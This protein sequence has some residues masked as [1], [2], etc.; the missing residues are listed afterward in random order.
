MLG[1]ANTSF[2]KELCEFTEAF[3]KLLLAGSFA[4]VTVQCFYYV[5]CNI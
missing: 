2:P 3:W 4:R 5:M 1:F